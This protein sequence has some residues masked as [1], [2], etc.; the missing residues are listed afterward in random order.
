[1][2]FWS[3]VAAS[4]QPNDGRLLAPWLLV[5]S[6]IE[7]QTRYQIHTET[8][9]GAGVLQCIRT[10]IAIGRSRESRLKRLVRQA[11]I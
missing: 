7:Q 10:A 3:G 4:E 9:K 5:R 8:E 2:E 1:M 6:A 11:P